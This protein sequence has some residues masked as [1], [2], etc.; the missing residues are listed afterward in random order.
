MK[1]Q[2]FDKIL[3]WIRIVEEDKNDYI[4]GM[5]FQAH[6]GNCP[7]EGQMFTQAMSRDVSK[8]KNLSSSVGDEIVTFRKTIDIPLKVC[9]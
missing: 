1:T 8:E 9:D 2:N 5:R 3:D 4:Q 7:G 6:S